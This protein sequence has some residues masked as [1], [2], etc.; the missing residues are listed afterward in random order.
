MLDAHAVFAS[1]DGSGE[2]ARVGLQIEPGSTA[3][4]EE[5][6]ALAVPASSASPVDYVPVRSAEPAPGASAA[7][8]ARSASPPVQKPHSRPASTMALLRGPLRKCRSSLSGIGSS[9]V[10]NEGGLFTSFRS[11]ARPGT[12]ACRSLRLVSALSLIHISEPTR[13]Y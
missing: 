5:I 11:R 6:W 9:G 13:P 3:G 7:V 8:C 1:G 10:R 4:F 2:S 12:R